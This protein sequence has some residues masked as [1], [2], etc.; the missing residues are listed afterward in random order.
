MVILKTIRVVCMR[1]D[2]PCQEMGKLRVFCFISKMAP[3]GLGAWD[4][5]VANWSKPHTENSLQYHRPLVP[6]QC[7]ETDPSNIAKWWLNDAFPCWPLSSLCFKHTLWSFLVNKHFTNIYIQ[8][9]SPKHIRLTSISIVCIKWQWSV[10]TSRPELPKFPWSIYLVP[11][12]SFSV[13][14]ANHF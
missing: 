13:A 6:V 8:C 7:S 9:F 1:Q 2:W 10:S 12:L 14:F 4:S 11:S 5:S 3:D